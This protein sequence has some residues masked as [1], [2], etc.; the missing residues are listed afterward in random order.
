MRN[1]ILISVL[2]L[3]AAANAQAVFIDNFDSLSPD[4]QFFSGETSS[5]FIYDVSGGQFRAFGFTPAPPHPRHSQRMQRRFIPVGEAG[6]TNATLRARISLPMSANISQ[7]SISLAT[8]LPQ[9]ILEGARIFAISPRDQSH[10]VLLASGNANDGLFVDGLSGSIDIEIQNQGPTA[11]LFINGAF[12]T[13]VTG[14]QF[15][16]QNPSYDTIAMG[17]SGAAGS[18]APVNIDYIQVVPEPSAMAAFGVASFI[19]AR[20]RRKRG[21]AS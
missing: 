4:W 19:A 7:L 16:N 18:S 17:F 13:T 14:S 6:I 10:V 8:G 11:T 2:T 21:R 9:G 12:V 20:R 3:F 1:P 5:Q 15:S